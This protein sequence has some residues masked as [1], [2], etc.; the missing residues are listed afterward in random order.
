MRRALLSFALAVTVAVPARANDAFLANEA[1]PATGVPQVPKTVADKAWGAA[2]PKAFRVSAQR[3]VHLN[4]KRANELLETPGV[5]EV[6]VRALVSGA[7]L[8]LLLEWADETKDVVRTDEVN[9]FA[10]SAAIEFPRTYGA[11]K[12][13]PY[14]G[15]GDDA[16][17]VHLYM[18][19]ATEKGTLGNEYVAAGF[20]SL[21]RIPKAQGTMSME[22]DGKAKVW[23]A[24]FVRPLK[25]EGSSVAE[26]LVPVAF[27]VWDGARNERGGYKQLSGWHFVKLPQPAVDPAYL[28]QLAWGYGAGELGD[29]AKG[30]AIAETICVACHHLPGK[31]LAAPGLAP[32]LANIGVI[33]TPAYLRESI[34]DPSGVI[35][36]ALQPN[37]HYSKSLPPDKN[38]A[39]PNADAF[40][41]STRDTVGKTVSKMPAFSMYTPEQVGDLVAFLKTLD[42]T[43]R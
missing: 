22:Y 26:A 12:R 32:S 18:Q 19:R 2:V 40:Q 1:V 43:R 14:V 36:H 30:Q 41:W 31:A 8:G 13:L 37:A 33:A 3:S 35:I 10:D 28:K 20:G 6:K 21:T 23:R 17:P 15:M 34:V 42:G 9:A 24:I 25:V 39:Y 5:A 11:G 38:G 29:P 27:A 7:E 4:D 16:M